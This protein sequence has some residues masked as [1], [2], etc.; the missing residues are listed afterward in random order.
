MT[1]LE[2]AL[3]ELRGKT[4]DELYPYA[5]LHHDPNMLRRAAR[6]ILRERQNAKDQ[7]RTN[8]ES[9]R[10]EE[11]IRLTKDGNRHAKDAVFWAIMAAILAGI[12]ILV[13]LFASM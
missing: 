13:T 9:N 3:E 8:I 5:D 10:H 11:V 2:K 4:D 6:Q 12:G 1:E 7:A